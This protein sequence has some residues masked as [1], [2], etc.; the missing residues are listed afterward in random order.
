M[1]SQTISLFMPNFDTIIF[2]LG[3]V[4]IDWNPDYVFDG[5]IADPERKQFFYNNV[6]TSDWNEEQDAGRSLQEATDLLLARHPEWETEILAYYGRWREM[7][8]GDIPD[9]VGILRKLKDADSH[10]LYALTNWSAET[11]PVA[12]E[13]FD[14]LHWFEGIVVSG[15]EKTR[16]PFDDF[17]QILFDR[18][19]VV[20]DQAVFVDDNKRNVEAGRRLGLMS[21]HF[22]SPQQLEE[23][24]R[25]IGV[26]PG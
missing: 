7:L 4:L 22:S 3:G 23:D 19:N 16:K 14:F 2:D 6:C 26:L 10:R 8:G 9:T 13:T 11:F 15:A 25:K 17:F 21:I 18:Y 24:L 12:L 20:P 5:L 1:P